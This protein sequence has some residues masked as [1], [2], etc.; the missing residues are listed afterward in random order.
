MF[1]KALAASSANPPTQP[2]Q[3]RTRDG[4]ASASGPAED[5]PSSKRRVSGGGAVPTGP[6]AAAGSDKKN[7]LDRM[8]GVQANEARQNQDAY[9]SKIDNLTQG[10]A[11]VGASLGMPQQQ[12]FAPQRQQHMNQQQQRGQF[13]NGPRHNQGQMNNNMGGFGGQ[14]GM[15]DMGMGGMGMN[16]M[17]MGVQEMMVST[18]NRNESLSHPR[19]RG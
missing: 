14:M 17:N 5:E 16:G 4:S 7:L 1:A 9:Q 10:A 13:P 3:K 15:G 12:A 2:G 11:A 6:R 8:G 19:A 18:P